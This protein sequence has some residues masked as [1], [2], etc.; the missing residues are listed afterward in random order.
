MPNARQAWEGSGQA[1]KWLKCI[2]GC[3]RRRLTV[4][5]SLLRG[6]RVGGCCFQG[7]QSCP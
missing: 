1:L 2:R 5:S 6:R 7:H 3:P 4:L